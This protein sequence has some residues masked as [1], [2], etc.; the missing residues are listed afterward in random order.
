MS[1]IA[2]RDCSIR[3]GNVRIRSYPLRIE[4]L[5]DRLVPAAPF[6]AEAMSSGS[7]SVSLVPLANVAVGV[8]ERVTFGIPFPRGSITQA[9]LANVRVLKNGVEVPAYVEQLTPWRSID[10]PAIDGQSVRVARIQ[11]PYTFAS[12]NPESVTV[13]WGGPARAINVTSIQDPRLE[14]HTVTSGTF[15]AADQVEE[16]DVLPVLPKSYI[17]KGM[18]DARTEPFDGAVQETRDDPATMAAMNFPGYSEYD[19]AEKN[20]FYTIINQNPGVAIDYKTQ[21]EPWQ[22]DRSAGIFELY[23]RSGFATA[24]REAVRSA[25]F[26]LDRLNSSGYFALAAGDP[27][28]SYNEG[29][30]YTYWLLG[31][32]RMLAPIS[33][34]VGAHAVTATHWDPALATWTERNI[35]LKL[36][37]TE[38]AYE[39]TGNAGFKSDL[40]A[41]VGDLIWHQNGAGGQ[42]PVN[43]V[44]GGLY[45]LGSQHDA[46]E[47]SGGSVLIA[48]PWMSALAADAMVR[49]Y[50]VWQNTQ[51]ADFLV[52]A[53]T[54]LK[55]ASKIDAAGQF[56]NT[57]RYPDNLTRTDGTSDSRTA[58][59][60]Q[61][62]IDVGGAAA[63]ANYFAEVRGTP[64]ATLRQLANDLY[65]TY[66]LGVNYWTQ[67]GSTNFNVAPPRRY[68]WEYKNSGSFSWAL[69]GTDNPTTGAHTMG[70][71]FY[72]SAPGTLS[73]SPLTTQSSGS[74]VLAWVGRGQLD[75]FG[76]STNPYDNLGNTATQ[77]GQTHSY[78]PNWPN[79]GMALYTFP[80]FAGGPGDIFSAP[81]PFGDE[82]TLIVTEVKNGG[83]I[84]DV[85][86][87]MVESGPLTSLN[88]T[89]TGPATLVAFW[90]GDDG[91]G[92]I[93]AV[94]NNGFTLLETQTISNNAVQSAMAT[95][96]VSAAGV[97]NVTWT[98]T[99]TQR[100]YLWL[101][102]IQRA[103]SPP[104]VPTVI[105]NDGSAQ[106]SRVDLL[107]VNFDAQV[108]FSGSVADAFTLTRTGG[109]AVNFSANATVV[110]GKT[111][112]TMT[113][114]TGSEAQ[115][116]SL[117][118]G[119][120]TL[121]AHS[122]Q[123]SVNG[124]PMDGDGDGS[125][126]GNLVFG[127]AQ[128]LFR[129]FGD[130]NGD[131]RVNIADYGLFSL[132]Y[133]N[134]ANY[135]PAFDFTGDGKIDIS[136]YGQFSIRYLAMLP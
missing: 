25:D 6:F 36:L 129:F 125:A 4:R 48:S 29:L 62:A 111:V 84:Q 114:F 46:G 50:G 67:P 65:A 55:A 34:V 136:D 105:V 122:S 83:V 28:Y 80:S 27:K 22:L 60:V 56:G 17:A 21:S 108:T 134:A 54:F 37:A 15:V 120:F 33:N 49:V 58:A 132:T 7:V 70:F 72:S 43:R 123:I 95:K 100:A 97:Y 76:S 69:T 78:A 115:F 18:L 42:L 11:I 81:N 118:D 16:P 13:Q 135:N 5:E 92:A 24:L 75:S 73:T 10:V 116:G 57:T 1:Q 93:S 64:D 79:S 74:T 12:L 110:G 113:N 63:W 126:G 101:V 103:E 94:P 44:D 8:Q 40:Q 127:E 45:H 61:H 2:R 107:T 98:A 128:G 89:T 19:Y 124:S 87:N 85:Q 106:R 71:T 133:R 130:I 66:D 117:K 112:V 68:T 121:T 102:A 99:P 109:G 30:A 39:V 32:N 9:Q 38:I 59:D 31:D 51:I 23:F 41:V 131:R 52:R 82:V 20:F 3:R 91:S 47:A 86:W 53:G 96:E 119:R 77:L 14:W 26:Y 90:T 88:V 104:A 35:A